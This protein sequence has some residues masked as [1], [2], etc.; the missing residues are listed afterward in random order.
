MAWY[1]SLG[2]AAARGG[3][4]AANERA[5]ELGRYL[6]SKLKVKLLPVVATGIATVGVMTGI[7]V[8]LLSSRKK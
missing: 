1:E 6:G 3:V 4:R 8:F 5:D 2:K 7:F